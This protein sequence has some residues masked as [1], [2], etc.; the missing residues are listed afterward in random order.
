M[1]DFGI[2]K[3]TGDASCSDDITDTG[4]VVGTPHFMSPEMVRATRPSI[5][6]PICGR[7]V[8]WPIAH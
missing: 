4:A 5:T 7:W 8:W 6:A 1:L 2:A 3:Q